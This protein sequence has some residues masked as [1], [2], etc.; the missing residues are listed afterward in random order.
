MAPKFEFGTNESCRGLSN[1]RPHRFYYMTRSLV[2]CPAFI[3]L[4]APMVDARSGLDR[5]NRKKQSLLGRGEKYCVDI[6]LEAIE[7]GRS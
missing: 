4:Y 7:G 3:F 2:L 5:V 6:T 1:R